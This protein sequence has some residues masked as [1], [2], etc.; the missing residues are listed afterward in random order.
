MGEAGR[1]DAPIEISTARVSEWDKRALP[2]FTLAIHSFPRMVL[3][4][5]QSPSQSRLV[6]IGLRAKTGRAIAVV[7]GGPPESPIVLLKTEISLIDPNLPATAQPYHAVMDLSWE[8]SE[9]RVRKSARAIERIAARAIATL[10]KT[11]LAEDHSV[12][13]VGIVGAPDRDLARIGNPHIRAHAA[14]GVLFR[15]VLERAAALNG[16]KSQTFSDRKFE[17]VT[18]QSLGARKG[19]IEASWNRLRRSVPPPWRTEEKQAATT[20]W[21]VLHD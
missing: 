17:E 4:R 7:L 5:R 20:A 10:V 8:E 19:S 11:Q 14:E 15:L 21:I 12:V 18:T 3:S 6:A 13:G 16:L 2:A 1:D 9:R